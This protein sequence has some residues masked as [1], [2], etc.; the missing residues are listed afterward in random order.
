MEKA[1]LDMEKVKDDMLSE[2]AQLKA[3]ITNPSNQLPSPMLSSKGSIRVDED[4]PEAIKLNPIV[5]KGLVLDDIVDDC[6]AIDPPP[7]D[8]QILKVKDTICAC[9]S[10]R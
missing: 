9:G 6:T 5:A 7:P 8:P 2:I 3:M 4:K 10:S 1:K